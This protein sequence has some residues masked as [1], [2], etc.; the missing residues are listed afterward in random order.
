MPANQHLTSDDRNFISFYDLLGLWTALTEDMFFSPFHIIM[1]RAS[2]SL[3]VS[4]CQKLIDVNRE[5]E[6]CTF[7]EN[8]VA[9]DVTAEALGKSRR[10]T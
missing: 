4:G 5:C 10:A 2:Y 3:P 7:C 6:L 1:S 8:P 9:T